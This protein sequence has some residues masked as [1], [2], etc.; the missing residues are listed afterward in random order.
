MS[1]LKSIFSL[2]SGIK[3][4][5]NIK[6]IR[7]DPIS[8]FPMTKYYFNIF[9]ESCNNSCVS[10]LHCIFKMHLNLSGHVQE[11]IQFHSYIT[12]DQ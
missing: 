4:K 10:V 2:I 11:N 9:I 1:W 3:G 6:T 8:K 12:S 5:A 7:R